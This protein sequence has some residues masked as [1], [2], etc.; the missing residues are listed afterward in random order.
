V[1][2]IR[3]ATRRCWVGNGET[4]A[5]ASSHRNVWRAE[6]LAD[7][8]GFSVMTVTLAEAVLPAPLSVEPTALVV[9]VL[10]ARGGAR[11]VHR[12]R[13]GSARRQRSCVRLTEPVPAAAMMA[14]PPQ[15]PLSPL[16]VATTRPPGNVSLKPTPS[17]AAR[18]WGGDGEAQAGARA[19]HNAGWPNDLPM[20]GG[21]GTLTVTLAVACCRCAFVR[22]DR[23]AVVLGPALYRDVHRERAG[24]ERRQRGPRQTRGTGPIRGGDGAPPQEPVRPLGVAITSPP[25][26][27]R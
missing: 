7:S 1:K 14:P 20:V 2:A 24:G 5:G 12:E 11:H 3:S 21:F 22:S 25:A 8:G 18:R 9:L 4:Q 16:G 19:H 26:R 27:C 6:R 23:G 15:V 13:A 17:S 10:R